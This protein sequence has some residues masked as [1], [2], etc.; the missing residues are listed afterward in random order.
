MKILIF[1]WVFSVLT[2]GAGCSSMGLSGSGGISSEKAKFSF[3]DTSGTYQMVKEVG[4]LQKKKQIYVKTQLLPENGN[5]DKA[6]EKSVAISQLGSL[7]T[8][9]GKVQVLLP[10]ISQY[11]VWLD[12]EKFFS[13]MKTDFLR[14]KMEI[15]LV[16]PEKKWQ[17]KSSVDLAEGENLYCFDSQLVECIKV[18]DFL[19]MSTKKKAGKMTFKLIWDKFPYMQESYANIPEEVWSDAAFSY[20]GETKDGVIKFVLNVAGQTIFYHFD[21]KQNFLKKFWVAQGISQV[22][23]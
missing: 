16:S 4:V 22:R 8:K 7:K 1:L 10:K 5:E 13:Q 19:R 14:R 11:T 15:I 2:L 23:Q 20:D 12:G 18:T 9:T 17:G 3:S 21:R 6:L